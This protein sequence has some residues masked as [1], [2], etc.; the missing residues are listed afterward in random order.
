MDQEGTTQR[1]AV[2][3]FN[4]GGPDSLE[5]VQPFLFNLFRDPAIIRLP[6]PLRWIIAKLISHKRVPE[7]VEIY[8]ALGGCSPLLQETRNQAVALENLLALESEVNVFFAML[9]LPAM[10]K[11]TSR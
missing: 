6:Q 5:A 7:A 9:F 2:V 1:L 10:D 11:E 3:L 4:L 8:E